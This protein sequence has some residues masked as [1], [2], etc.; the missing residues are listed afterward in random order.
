MKA[1]H[2]YDSQEWLKC[3]NLFQESLQQFWE[4]LEDCRAEC[5]YLVN[6][7]IVVGDENNEWNVFITSEYFYWIIKQFLN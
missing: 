5:E 2:A 7:E 4:A 6:E 3:V 1:V